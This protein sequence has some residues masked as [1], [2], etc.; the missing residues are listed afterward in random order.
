MQL[1]LRVTRQNTL[2][3]KLKRT[4]EK[5]KAAKQQ[6]W[7]QQSRTLYSWCRYPVKFVKIARASWKVYLRFGH[8]K[9]AYK[10]RLKCNP[11]VYNLPYVAAHIN[12]CITV[13]KYARCAIVHTCFSE[14]TG[15]RADKLRKLI[16]HSS[17][18]VNI[19]NLSNEI[20]IQR[21]F[22]V[23]DCYL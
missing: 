1:N 9:S 18:I 7:N 15:H 20:I 17:I 13:F 3:T 23:T 12:H 2:A 19:D 8:F 4:V 14:L 11:V 21:K 10:F 16:S 22:D 6:R 5:W